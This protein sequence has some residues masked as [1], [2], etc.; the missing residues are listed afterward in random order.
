M[1]VVTA[2]V[3]E[4]LKLNGTPMA[5]VVIGVAVHEFISCRGGQRARSRFA[6]SGYTS[7]E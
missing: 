1:I 5:R 2:E 4:T 3:L 6:Q 7:P